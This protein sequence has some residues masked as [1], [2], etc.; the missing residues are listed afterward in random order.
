M[1]YFNISFI[2]GFIL[3]LLFIVAGCNSSQNNIAGWTLIEDG[4]QF[5]EDLFISGT[6]NYYIG[7][8]TALD[9]DSRGHILIADGSEQEIKILNPDGK[10]L[11]SIGRQGKGPGEFSALS[12]VVVARND[13]IYAL[14]S[15]LQRISVFNPDGNFIRDLSVENDAGMPGRLLVPENDHGFAVQYT[16]SFCHGAGEENMKIAV[17]RINSHGKAAEKLLEA[18]CREAI[19]NKNDGAIQVLSKPFGRRP[20]FDMKP[21]A[22]YYG[23]S[24]S[25]ASARYNLKGDVIARLSLP[26][27][28]LPV[29]KEDLDDR[30]A[31]RPENFQDD[32][33]KGSHETKPAFDAMLVDQ[34]HRVWFKR[35]TSNPEKASW[36]V[37][38]RDE[39]VVYTVTLP[40]DIEL[41]EI[42]DGYAYGRAESD[43]GEPSIARYR[44]VFPK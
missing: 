42:T 43:R 12:D 1:N 3:T 26:H 6:D 32:L 40:A 33:R 15:N 22:I 11:R 27:D 36:W 21:D 5:E 23:W 7:R 37:A 13:S 31:D 35:A 29:T 38:D 24:D 14:D 10:L 9:V 39:R 19:V 25:L 41:L 44:I 18:P 20:A 2:N 34:E 8:V 17:L 28:P 30:I 16:P 4:L